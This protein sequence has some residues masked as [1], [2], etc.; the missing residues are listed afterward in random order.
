MAKI[1]PDGTAFRYA[2]FLGGTCMDAG[3]GI[4]VD[5][6]GS[7]W[8]VGNTTSD[9]FPIKKGAIE[10]SY[11]QGGGKGF[12]ARLTPQ[13]NEISYATFLGSAATTEATAVA[14]D[15]KGN[16]YVA[17]TTM[18]FDRLLFGGDEPFPFGICFLPISRFGFSCSGSYLGVAF[19]LKLDPDGSS[20]TYLH[21]LG[22]N[23]SNA[24]A[25]AVDAAGKAWV[26]G[27]ERSNGSLFPLVNPIQAFG[28]DF[29]SQ[30]SADGSKL[31]F[32]SPMDSSVGLALDASGN[33]FFTGHTWLDERVF[34]YQ[35]ALVARVDSAVP[36]A[37]TVEVPLP[38][39]SKLHRPF[40]TDGFVGPGE[41]VVINGIGMGPSQEV[42][43]QLTAQGKVPTTLSGASVY[44]DGV[45][46]PLLSVQDKRLVCIVPFAIASRR[47]GTT[48][49]VE[50]NGSKSNTI[51]LGITDTAIEVLAI[52][53]QDGIVNSIA[54]PASPSS[55]ITI[56][57]AGYG[58]T[59]PPSV[60]GEINGNEKRR[61]GAST[62]VKFGDRMAEVTYAGPAPGQVAGIS[63]INIRVPELAPGQYPIYLGWDPPYSSLTQYNPEFVTVG[64]K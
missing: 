7:A 49:Q 45:A 42:R 57:V 61:L 56:Y 18:G 8:I 59:N 40:N 15:A 1:S 35:V 5:S 21:I 41:I 3:S 9:D 38:I 30:I 2:T 14:L 51:V 22:G 27:S 48:M 25:V 32:S 43:S 11:G 47:G 54:K 60:D 52:A 4:A 50:S 24:N 33:A 26:S 29:L 44:F 16:V 37:V 17:G 64:T 12:L 13:G 19:V 63:Q 58:Q 55:V 53:N 28:F 20:R 36:F 6:S 46:A 10:P 34:N 62:A 23:F 31:L 39:V